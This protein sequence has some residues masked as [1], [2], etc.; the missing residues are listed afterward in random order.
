MIAMDLRTNSLLAGCSTTIISP[1]SRYPTRSTTHLIPLLLTQSRLFRVPVEPVNRR[2]SWWKL[3]TR[4][5]V[6][7]L[8]QQMRITNTSQTRIPDIRRAWGNNQELDTNL[9]ISEGNEVDRLQSH[10]RNRN[11]LRLPARN[12]SAEKCTDLECGR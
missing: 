6:R 5:P 12:W 4:N 8:H 7:L 9:P 11:S 1:P 10:N 3:N 2:P